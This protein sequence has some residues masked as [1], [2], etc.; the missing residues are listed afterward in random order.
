[1]D[2]AN[3]LDGVESFIDS[4][5]NLTIAAA[6][7][8]LTQK[9]IQYAH[10]QGLW[11][12]YNFQEKLQ[13]IADIVGGRTIGYNPFPTYGNFQPTF[14]LG[15]AVNKTSI[16][17]GVVWGLA[18]FGVLGAKWKRRGQKILVGGAIG[19]IF[20]APTSSSTYSSGGAEDQANTA[21]R[22]NMALE[23]RTA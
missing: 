15:Q 1:M 21:R 20:D 3:K 16:V 10:T 5:E 14:N 11:S 8:Q 7:F 22:Y 6:L 17:G 23:G 9:D 18:E 12:K 2:L 19:G 4:D 13:L